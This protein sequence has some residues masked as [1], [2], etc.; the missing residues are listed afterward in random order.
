[1]DWPEHLLRDRREPVRAFVTEVIGQ[2]PYCR[3]QVRRCD[4][5][6]IDADEVIG[7]FACVTT[8]EGSCGIC[9]KEV[10]RKHK[11]ELD[12][13]LGLVHRKC[14]DDRVRRR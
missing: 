6:G 10:S 4:S 2:C 5:R 14:L 12:A 9:K 8:V 13:R 11:R 3:K 1:M 7:C